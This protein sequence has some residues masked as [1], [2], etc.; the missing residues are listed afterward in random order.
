MKNK[1][2]QESDELE[3]LLAF[4]KFI[5]KCSFLIEKFTY[6][7]NNVNEAIDYAESHNLYMVNQLGNQEKLHT[8]LSNKIVFRLKV[9]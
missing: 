1:A 9:K 6:T 8:F 3:D 7:G 2:E 4:A 5:E